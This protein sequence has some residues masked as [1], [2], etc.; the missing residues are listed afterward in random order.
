MA[1]PGDIRNFEVA[2]QLSAAR[3]HAIDQVFGE[4]GTAKDVSLDRRL[5]NEHPDAASGFEVGGR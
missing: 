3:G 4:R 2:F 1:H 5:A